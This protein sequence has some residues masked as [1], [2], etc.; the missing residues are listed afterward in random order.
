MSRIVVCGGSMIGLTTAMML[1]N[2]GHAVT[3]LEADPGGVPA[4]GP[5]AWEA[6]RRR[7]VAQFHQ[8]HSLLTRFRRVCDQELPGL[9]R[10]LQ[11]AGCVTIDYLQQMPRSITDRRPR[12]GDEHCWAVTGRRPV[13][14]SVVA[15]A[16]LEH[17]G[18]EIR[19][20]VR[21]AGLCTGANVVPGVPHVS[22]VRTA[23]GSR[24]QADLVVDAMGRRTPSADW[25]STVGAAV[26]AAEELDRGFVYY[27]RYFT[28]PDR[29]KRRGP[30]LQPMGSVSLLTLESDNDTWSVTLFGLTGDAPLKN[31]RKAD[32]FTRVVSACPRVAHWLDGRPITE[33]VAM[34]GIL[35]RCRRFAVDGRPAVTGFAAVGDS[36]ACTNPSAGRGLS[37]GILQAQTLRHLVR[38]HLDDPATFAAEWDARTERDVAPF[39]RNQL[40]ADS[41]RIAEMDAVRHGRPPAPPADAAMAKLIAA[42]GGDPDAFRGLLDI[43]LCTALPQEVFARPGMTDRI[44]KACAE[45][46]PP[47]RP[48]GPDRAQLLALLAA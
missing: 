2:D 9:N 15:A 7:G 12:P 41:A 31:L 29:P 21:V 37:V 5:G 28:G 34:A 48:A 39:V 8:P 32:T 47:R 19:R 46:P 11:G 17:R 14:E 36:W 42:A 30:P 16:A 24:L 3:V 35:D 20:G 23:D 27:T 6:W 33:V 22:G 18:V 38:D 44:E 43:F 25:L 40:A 10:R 4:A 1:A 26:P 13:V 45:A